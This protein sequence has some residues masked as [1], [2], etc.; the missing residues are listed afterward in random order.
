MFAGITWGQF[1]LFLL[2]AI[3]IYY[4]VVILLYYRAEVFGKFQEKKKPADLVPSPVAVPVISA[5]GSTP[6][7]GSSLGA[8]VTPGGTDNPTHQENKEPEITEEEGSSDASDT[9]VTNHNPELSILPGD[10]ENAFAV[11]DPEEDMFFDDEVNVEEQFISF[12]EADSIEVLTGGITVAELDRTVDLLQ[13]EEISFSEKREL[14]KN[15]ELIEDSFLLQSITTDNTRAK[16][17]LDL[18]FGDKFFAEEVPEIGEQVIKDSFADVD[19]KKL[20]KH[21]IHF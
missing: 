6:D 1:G 13:Q 15:L 2:V 17:K 21:S 16:E 9:G 20:M 19:V 8:P 11:Q 5:I 10:D 14:S 4:V 3:S 12:E 7:Y 18:L